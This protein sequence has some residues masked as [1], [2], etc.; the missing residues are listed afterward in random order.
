MA[1]SNIPFLPCSMQMHRPPEFKRFAA[2]YSFCMRVL[3]WFKY[4]VPGQGLSLDP[5][6]SLSASDTNSRPLEGPFS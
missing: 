4:H 3:L 6:L 1:L 2:S 5:M